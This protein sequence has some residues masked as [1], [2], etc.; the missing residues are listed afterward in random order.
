MFAATSIAICMIARTAS[1]AMRG[2]ALEED[3]TLR[4]VN[5]GLAEGADRISFYERSCRH[6]WQPSG[7]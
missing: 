6:L 3:A 7:F 5:P 1:Y 2:R 4:P